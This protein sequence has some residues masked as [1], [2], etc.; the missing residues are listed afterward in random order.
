MKYCSECGAEVEWRQPE[1]D[2]RKRFVCV[3]CSTIHYQNPK[4]VAGCIPVWQDKVLLCRR[5]IEPRY[6]KWTLPAGFMEN[7]E[8]TVE[9]ALRETREEACAQVDVV[10]LFTMLS[11]PHISQVYMMYRGV[12]L[13]EDFFPGEESL[14]TR[15]FAEHEIPWDEMAFP[16]ITAT[17]ELFFNDR[18]Q[19]NFRI[20]TGEMIRIPDQQYAFELNCLNT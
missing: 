1:G 7:Q 20:H 2:N 19:G 17:L 3:E 5:G 12:L 11:L 6:G 14:E 16:V 13:N 18:K 4:I 9:A 15:L 10:D 8:T